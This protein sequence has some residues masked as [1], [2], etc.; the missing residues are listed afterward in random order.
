M[1]GRDRRR[2]RFPSIQVGWLVHPALS[3]RNLATIGG[4][5]LNAK[6]F[7]SF[8]SRPEDVQAS[9]IR[10]LYLL[11]LSQAVEL[12]ACSIRLAFDRLTGRA[13]ELLERDSYARTDTYRYRSEDISTA[14]DWFGVELRDLSVLD[15]DDGVLVEVFET[16]DTILV[17]DSLARNGLFERVKAE[18]GYWHEP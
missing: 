1:F 2:E 8:V 7:G 12:G 13:Q 4:L 9:E 5:P 6:E 15:G 10:A 11:T 16:W 17:S 14:P 18:L 3:P